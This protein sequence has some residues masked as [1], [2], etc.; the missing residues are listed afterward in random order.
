MGIDCGMGRYSFSR[1]LAAGANLG[2]TV[3]RECD[4]NSK[5][6]P[7]NSESSSESS[8]HGIDPRQDVPDVKVD[9]IEVAFES[10]FDSVSTLF[11][12]SGSILHQ[13]IGL[14]FRSGRAHD[15]HIEVVK[16][17]ERVPV[18]IERM[19]RKW[20]TVAHVRLAANLP[21]N[22]P[23]LPHPERRSLAVIEIYAAQ[24]VASA[25]CRINRVVPEMRRGTLVRKDAAG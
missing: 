9:L 16:A 12:E 19:Q 13:I 15:A 3:N 11:R 23:G 21:D 20:G 25:Y 10:V 2:V 5:M 7:E 1:A 14:E 4:G 22:I 8:S 24:S 6:T 17:P 18:L